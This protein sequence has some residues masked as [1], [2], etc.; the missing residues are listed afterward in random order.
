MGVSFVSANLKRLCSQGLPIAQTGWFRLRFGCF[1][2]LNVVEAITTPVEWQNLLMMSKNSVTSVFW[3]VVVFLPKWHMKMPEK[4]SARWQGKVHLWD[5]NVVQSFWFKPQKAVC[6]MLSL[7]ATFSKWLM[8]AWLVSEVGGFWAANTWAVSQSQPK[9][10]IFNDSVPGNRS[11]VTFFLRRVSGPKGQKC[12]M[13]GQGDCG[14]IQK[15]LLQAINLEV[16][17]QQDSLQIWPFARK[18]AWDQGEK[19]AELR[20]WAL[21]SLL[22]LGLS[23]LHWIKPTH[24][25]SA[26]SRASG[27]SA[28]AAGSTLWWDLNQ[29]REL[30][31]EQEQYK[32]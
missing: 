17:F 20:H 2:S 19:N 3:C 27:A 28:S 4:A 11:S 32:V 23:C 16:S 21:C 9:R 18:A 13:C 8:R 6:V 5:K 14:Q 29:L 15:C 30:D 24:I 7:R 26:A 1:W 31:I 10:C 22:S 12:P 25:S